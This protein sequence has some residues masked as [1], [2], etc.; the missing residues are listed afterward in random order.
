MIPDIS[1][2]GGKPMIYAPLFFIVF[3]T[4]CKDLAEDY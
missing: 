1:E 3:I 4:A 2:T